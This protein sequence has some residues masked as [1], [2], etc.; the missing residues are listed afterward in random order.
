MKICL[1]PGHGGY[2]P[3]ACG[4]GLK[5]KDLTLAICLALKPLLEYNCINVILT[6]DGD[7]A[8]GHFEG[9]K[10]AELAERV[11]IANSNKVDLMLSTHINAGGGEGEEVLVQHFG[12]N[13]E[14][15]SDIMLPLLTKAGG[16]RSRGVKEQNVEVL[17]DTS[18]PAILT[19]NGFIDSVTDT[20]KLKD[21]IFRQALAVAHARG[22]CDYFE[23][24]YK[25]EVPVVKT[26]SE[27]TQVDPTP[28]V[29]PVTTV[30][31]PL[32][33]SY[34]NNAQV[35]GDDLYIRDEN[36]A[37]LPGHQVDNGDKITILDVGY[38]SQL[39]K[40]EYPTSTGARTGYIKNVASL[41]KYSHQ[42]EWQNGS[43]SETVFDKEGRKIGS[44][45]PH[46][47]ATPI[48]RYAGMLHVVYGTDKGLNTKSG[49][50]A[51]SGGFNKF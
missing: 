43:T 20:T 51:Y 33:F 46:E 41:I 25:E 28:P 12:G 16:W 47:K 38:T 9:N 39:A 22:I 18:M 49:Y 3:G 45:D 29:K 48:F 42:G 1:D 44:I 26:V 17:R 6:R 4:N 50:V 14:K 10:Y 27:P 15:L 5:E 34:P 2:D 40:L 24:Q 21:P 7:Y 32:H 23:I 11:R 35:L 13:A 36:G 19:E 30:S 37:R 31:A 8:P